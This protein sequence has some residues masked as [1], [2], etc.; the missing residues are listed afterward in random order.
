MDIWSAG[1]VLFQLLHEGETVFDSFRPLG[2]IALAMAIADPRQK[3]KFDWAGGWE[4]ARA[5]LRGTVVSVVRSGRGRG[6][7][8]GGVVGGRGTR[9]SGA[10]EFISAD[11]GA[12]QGRSRKGRVDSGGAAR[13]RRREEEDAIVPRDFIS[14]EDSDTAVPRDCAPD[15]KRM[16]RSGLRARYEKCCEFLRGNPESARARAKMG[17]DGSVQSDGDVQRLIYAL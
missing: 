11:G 8:G 14:E 17:G 6:V 2:R 4:R 16:V 15:L 7:V 10:R 12:G 3:Q 9:G 1:M 13:V 5:L